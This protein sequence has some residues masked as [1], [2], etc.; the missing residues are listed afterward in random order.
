VISAATPDSRAARSKRLDRRAQIARPVINYDNPH[1]VQFL[2]TGTRPM[3]PVALPLARPSLG[4]GG[5][6][7]STSP[8][9]AL[10]VCQGLLR[11]NFEGSVGIIGFNHIDQM[12]AA[13]LE[14]RRPPVAALQR[15]YQ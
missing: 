5:V 11:V 1:Q 14:G 13:A 15:S 3:E 12:P 8:V 6:F 2:S 4:N 10:C 7:G 9:L